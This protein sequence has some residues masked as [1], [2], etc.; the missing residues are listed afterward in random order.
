MGLFS[1]KGPNTYLLEMSSYKIKIHARGWS[2]DHENNQKSVT[3]DHNNEMNHSM[4][5]EISGENPYYGCGC[6]AV[7]LSASTLLEESQNMPKRCGEYSEN[8]ITKYKLCF[9][10]F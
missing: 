5:F 10:L 6:V 7:L 2:N 9:L 3:P 1:P 8:N 4:N